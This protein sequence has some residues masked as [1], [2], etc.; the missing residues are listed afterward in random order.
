M[1]PSGQSEQ[2]LPA[3]QWA[4]SQRGGA[5][6]N[7]F[8]RNRRQLA[9]IHTL[10]FFVHL[11]WTIASFSA[12]VGKDMEVDIFRV[13]PAW[14]NTGRNGYGFVVEK[15]IDWIRIDYVTA[16]FF[17]LSALSH[18]VWVLSFLFFRLF[19]GVWNGLTLCIEDCFCW[20]YADFRLEL[21]SH[22]CTLAHLH[23]TTSLYF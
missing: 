7:C 23:T 11:S 9:A 18:S 5:G 15:D 20:W 19:P 16:G 2:L 12:G 22:T 8:P 21:R 17:L 4:N 14:N 13:R 6:Y 3:V 1:K 10:C